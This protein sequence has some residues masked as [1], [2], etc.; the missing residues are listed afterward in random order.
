MWK[1][2][3]I[4]ITGILVL[5]LLIYLLIDFVW[6]QSYPSTWTVQYSGPAAINS[7]DQ[8]T[9]IATDSSGNV[10]VTGFSTGTGFT[11]DYTTVKYDSDGNELWSAL[12]DGPVGGSDR[13][14]DICIDST[15]AIYVTGKSEGNATYDFATVKYDSDGNELWAVRYDGPSGGSDEATAIAIDNLNNVYV[16]G[17]STDRGADYLTV[18]Y[19]SNGNELWTARYNSPYSS[20]DSAWD[21]AVDISGNAYVTGFSL[22]NGTSEDYATIKYDKDGDQIWVSRYDGPKSRDDRASLIKLDNAGNIYVTGYSCIGQRIMEGASHDDLAITTIKYAPDGEQLWIAEHSGPDN[23]QT[24][25]NDLA[26]DENGNVY[27]TGSTSYLVKDYQVVDTVTIKYDR[28]GNELW[29]AN[30]NSPE[31]LE[32]G[33]NAIALD[34]QGNVFIAGSSA[35]ISGSADYITVKYNNDGE[36]LWFS[37][38]NGPKGLR[39]VAIAMAIDDSGNVFVTGYSYTGDN[40]TN[41]VT[42][43]YAP[44]DP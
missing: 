34:D 16:T 30:Y 4:W 2:I 14:Y 21:I 3:L 15:D 23:S 35:S 8:A 9:N 11:N 39:D 36:Q 24:V 28:Y 20:I 10:Y 38:Y 12:Y 7:Y 6:N 25:A 29:V 27:V 37:R 19:D 13:A 41:Y 1:R 31:K 42:I 44:E 32:D 17:Y 18:K 22:G 40:S 43:K 33:A 26:V 5:G